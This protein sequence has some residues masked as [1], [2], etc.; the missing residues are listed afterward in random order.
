LAY[1]KIEVPFEVR[2]SFPPHNSITD[3]LDGDRFRQRS[4][5]LERNFAADIDSLGFDT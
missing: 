3:A 2:V 5:I 4:A 1:L